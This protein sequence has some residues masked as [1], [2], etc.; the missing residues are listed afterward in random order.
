MS[1]F[2]IKCIESITGIKAHT[3][4]IWEQRYGFIKPKRTDTNIRYY[5]DADLK[6]ILNVSI[7]NNYGLKISEISRMSSEE[8]QDMVLVISDDHSEYDNQINALSSTMLGLDEKGFN[9]ILNTSI[10][11]HGLEQTMVNIIFPFLRKVGI[12]WL[13]NTVHPAHEHFVSNLIKQKLYVAIDGQLSKTSTSGKSFLLFLPEGE[14]HE[15]GLLFANYVL[16]NRGH[17]VIYLGKSIPYED[18]KQVLTF[19]RPDYIFSTLT[20]SL[21]E[22]CSQSF[23]QKIS[24]IWDDTRVILTGEQ[25]LNGCE[26]ELPDNVF[27]VSNLE[28]LSVLLRN[29]ERVN[30]EKTN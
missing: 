21:A 10:I 26:L 6:L 16:R 2:S 27:V 1:N 17:E 14:S 13:A 30:V 20:N 3:L 12:L 7:L 5:D 24:K 18:L 28:E 8:I 19:Y 23:I 29:E 15:V 25:I 22:D 9:R 4:R 11:Q